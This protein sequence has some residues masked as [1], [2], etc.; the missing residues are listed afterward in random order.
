MGK[1]VEFGENDLLMTELA[2]MVWFF[3]HT[4]QFTKHDK[5][6]FPRLASWDS[7]DHGGRYDTFQL[8]AGIKESEGI[9]TFE[10]HLKRPGEQLRAELG[11]HVDK[12]ERLQF[13]MTCP[14]ELEAKLKMCQVHGPYCSERDV[15]PSLTVQ[16]VGHTSSDVMLTSSEQGKVGAHGPN[17]EQQ[18]L[19]PVLKESSALPEIDKGEEGANP[20]GGVCCVDDA[21]MEGHTLGEE[22]VSM[23]LASLVGNVEAS[24]AAG[25]D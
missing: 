6:R 4:T 7:V 15:V 3:E 2:R 5:G 20:E 1:K 22:G 17:G 24:A 11:K 21:T 12:E 25:I 18:H 13:W 8:V 19:G 14:K 16:D 10:K 23:A 9:L